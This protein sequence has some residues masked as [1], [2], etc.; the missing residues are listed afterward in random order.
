MKASRSST[1]WRRTCAAVLVAGSVFTATAWAGPPPSSTEKR[2]AK[3]YLVIL[4]AE[5]KL[6][7]QDELQAKI[8][9]QADLKTDFARLSSTDFAGLNPC[10]QIF[11]ANSFA[12]KAEAEDYGRKLQALGVTSSVRQS[13]AYANGDAARQ[14]KCAE[15][16]QA[17]FRFT[18]NPHA[19]DGTAPTFNATAVLKHADGSEEL[20]PLK[21]RFAD[22]D[23][24]QGT[25]QAFSVWYGGG[26]SDVKMVRKGQAVVVLQR[27]KD[28]GIPIAKEKDVEVARFALP[29]NVRVSGLDK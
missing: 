11:V 15:V 24:P 1:G 9:K 27:Y 29:S 14:K 28:E 2:F 7:P 13:G 21:D 25:P 20:R 16:W 8:S 26:G 19:E 10:L 18:A 17:F 23:V 6:G 3:R 5:P 12:S 4:A 22:S